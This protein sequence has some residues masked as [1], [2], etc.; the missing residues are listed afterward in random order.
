M[1]KTNVAIIIPTLNRIEFIYRTLKYYKSINCTH[2]IY[3]GDASNSSSESE[4]LKLAGKSLNVK[5]FHWPGMPDT[6]TNSNLAKEASTE[7]KFCAFHGDD[8][9]FVP[10]SLTL[11]ASFLQSNP[12]YAT[13]QG[14]AIVFSLDRT[15]PYG[16]I[17]S[18]STYWDKNGLEQESPSERLLH[19]SKNYW[20]PI[21]SVHRIE[22]YIEDIYRGADTI[23]DQNFREITNCF[24]AA[25]RGKSKF[26]DCF[27]LAR[28]VHDAIYH[29]SNAQ[30]VANEDWFGSLRSS[31]NEIAMILEKSV[32]NSKKISEEAFNNYLESLFDS[33]DSKLLLR[34]FLEKY[35]ILILAKKT[36]SVLNYFFHYNAFSIE[37]LSSKRSK[38]YEEFGPIRKVLESLEK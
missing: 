29:P 28:N 2:G 20:V 32:K 27:Y 30:W 9:F 16:K 1:S 19:I 36:I 22:N 3:I 12:D 34:N 14:R 4:V 6:T 25:I 11:C 10:K 31:K 33:Q 8:D 23:K 18:L 37:A 21:F 35:H 13:A 5:Y 26:I 17:K 7:Y 15:G 38:Y 24:G